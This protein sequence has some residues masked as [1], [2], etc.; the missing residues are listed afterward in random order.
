MINLAYCGS[1][2]IPFI[3][4]DTVIE[5][6]MKDVSQS[7]KVC[8][9]S[10]REWCERL[11]S[12]SKG[13]L[14]RYREWC[15]VKGVLRVMWSRNRKAYWHDSERSNRQEAKRSN[16]RMAEMSNGQKCIRIRYREVIPNTVQRCDVIREKWVNIRRGLLIW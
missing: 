11:K 1:P 10:S 13:L 5:S 16:G 3:Q 6:Y 12:K 15:G 7:Q 2:L 9:C 14:M 8:W 4:Q